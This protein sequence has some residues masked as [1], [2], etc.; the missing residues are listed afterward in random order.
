VAARSS[1]EADYGAGATLAS[2]Y[3][4]KA[5]IGEGGMATVWRAVDLATGALVAIKLA[6]PDEPMEDTAARMRAEARIE[7]ELVHPGIVRSLGH[8]RTRRGRAFLVLEL[9]EGWSLRQVLDAHGALPPVYAVRMLLPVAEALCFVHE[10]A[11]IHRDLK[12]DN[13]FI[14][15]EHGTFRPKIL[16]FGIAKTPCSDAHT[17]RHAVIGSPGYMAPEQACGMGDVDHRADIWAFCALLREAIGGG[18]AS[19]DPDA[20]TRRNAE[21]AA[22]DGRDAPSEF[23]ADREL[24]AIVRRGLAVDRD[25]RFQSMHEL[26]RALTRWLLAQGVAV[27]VCGNRLE[28]SGQSVSVSRRVRPP[29]MAARD[30]PALRRVRRHVVYLDAACGSVPSSALQQQ[31]GR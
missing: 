1:D 6:L 11:I 26:A 23:G 13:V 14:A 3:R 8:G 25:Q 21:R 16:D 30:R 20:R 29:Q 19:G 24:W 2:R 18:R 4:L 27:D 12:P 7:A 22:L 10:R 9:L 17:G 5:L 31:D 28:L 15:N